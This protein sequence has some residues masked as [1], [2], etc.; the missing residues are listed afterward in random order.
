MKKLYARLVL[1]LIDPALRERKARAKEED[2]LVNAYWRE[3]GFSGGA[4]Q[5]ACEGALQVEDEYWVAR[6]VKDGLGEA[7]R[8]GLLSMPTVAGDD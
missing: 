7:L 5:A 8:R 2:R 4:W 1:W 6:G 3:R